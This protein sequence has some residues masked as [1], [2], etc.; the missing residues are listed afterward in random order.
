MIVGW[1][2]L[3]ACAPPPAHPIRGEP[4]IVYGTP[5]GPGY[6]TPKSRPRAAEGK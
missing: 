2:A 5:H 6:V 3:I 4:D 1:V